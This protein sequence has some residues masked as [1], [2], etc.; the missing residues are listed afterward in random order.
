MSS[1][2]RNMHF[3]DLKCEE[4]KFRTVIFE[5]YI[6]QNNELRLACLINGVNIYSDGLFNNDKLTRGKNGNKIQFI[7]LNK[8]VIEIQ[9]DSFIIEKILK[10]IYGKY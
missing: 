9:T 7:V 6:K 8:S 4:L 1:N 5:K 2:N 3:P 10:I